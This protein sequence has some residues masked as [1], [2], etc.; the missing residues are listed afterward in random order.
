MKKLHSLLLMI[1]MCVSLAA[2]GNDNNSEE[3]KT[4]AVTNIENKDDT[5]VVEDDSHTDTGS[6]NE[7]STQ[8]NTIV[9]YFSATGNTQSI[10]ESIANGLSADIYEIVPKNTYSDA[11]LDYNDNNS[12]STLE[13]N[14]VSARPEILGTIGNF[15]QYDT[16]F[17]GYPIW[18]GEA[19]RIMD[20]FVESYDFTGKTIIPFCTSASSGIGSSADTLEELAGTGNWMNGQRFNESE[21]ADKVLE[22]AKQF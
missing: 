10:A 8:R 13:M 7:M 5:Q 21:S 19:P 16:V 3:K 22:W 14:D 4:A 11:D 2:C 17:L 12:R 1:A 9:V 6:E 15:E 20:T 18:W